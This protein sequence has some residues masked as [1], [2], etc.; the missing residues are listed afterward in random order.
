MQ[1]NFSEVSQQVCFAHTVVNTVQCCLAARFVQICSF[2]FV[3]VTETL[4]KKLNSDVFSKVCSMCLPS[5]VR[6]TK[7]LTV[8]VLVDG[9]KGKS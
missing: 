5:S 7:F 4:K 2:G 6:D 9:K 8:C 3:N 1:H